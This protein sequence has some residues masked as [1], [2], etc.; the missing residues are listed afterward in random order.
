MARYTPDGDTAPVLEAAALWKEKCLINDR[1]FFIDR[2]NIWTLENL[3]I[4]RSVFCESG[5]EDGPD[6]FKIKL[7]RQLKNGTAD[8]AILMAEIIFLLQLFPRG[9]IGVLAKK[10]LIWSAWFSF[11]E[12][13]KSIMAK[14]SSSMLVGI[15]SAGTAY[16]TQF[17]KEIKYF[18]YKLIKYK[19]LTEEDRRNVACD[20]IKFARWLDIEPHDGNRQARHMIR[21]ICFPDFYERISS[22]GNKINIINHFNNMTLN[23]NE[24]SD[25]QI[26]DEL[27]AIRGRLISEQKT[28][29]ID[30]YEP[31]NYGWKSQR[32]PPPPPPP[33]EPTIQPSQSYG[34]SDILKDGCFLDHSNIGRMLERLRSKKNLILQGPPGTGK[35]WLAKR[36]AYAIVGLKDATKVR[37][38]QFHPNLS[39]EDFVRGW[40]PT[41]DGK[42][43]LADGVF[44]EAIKAAS[45]D[46]DSSYVVV[47]EEINRGNP[48]QIFGELLTLLEA[49][50]RNPDEALELCHGGHDPVHI[51]PNL[52]VIGTM[53]IAD[54]SLALVDLAL[55]RR[56]AFI[57]LEPKLGAAWRKWVTDEGNIAPELVDDIERRITD[58]N[59]KIAEDPRLGKQFRIGHSYVTP[60]APLLDGTTREWFQQVVETEIRPLLDEYWFDAPKVSLDASDQ[61]L[62]G[63]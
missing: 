23:E 32:R 46:P 60:D 48:A 14:V 7:A 45:E 6:N 2:D 15:G 52:Y 41:G 38:V 37:A 22:T 30:F 58:L 56:F 11:D 51:P 40:R 42:L 43:T 53:N 29:N 33:E 57:E 36:L 4:L 54:R 12:N 1:S 24:W 19:S 34:I 44:M 28:E 5:D 39:Y 31:P 9:M 16:I 18:I 20:N 50:K 63:W 47:I 26:D 10:E 27:F 13:P 8:S 62:R 35:T 25:E 59:T 17:W 55:R 3:N 61:L 21:Y 49:G